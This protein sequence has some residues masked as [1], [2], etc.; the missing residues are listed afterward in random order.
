MSIQTDLEIQKR[1]LGDIL[2][3]PL[4]VEIRQKLAAFNPQRMFL[5]G[6]R[7]SGTNRA[8]SDYDILL[9]VKETSGSRSENMQKAQEL[10]FD[11]DISADVFVY[12]QSEFEEWK[13]ELNSVAEAAHNLG[14]EIPLG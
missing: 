8:D 5:F 10:L 2:S 14:V 11:L 4:I 13:N 9:V 6:S 12:S 3:D 1:S 7:A